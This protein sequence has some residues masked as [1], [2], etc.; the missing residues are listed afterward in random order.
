M[1]G[2]TTASNCNHMQVVNKNTFQYGATGLNKDMVTQEKSQPPNPI[3]GAK[4][5]AQLVG[6][7]VVRR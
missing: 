7:V 4:G 3:I 2:G 1:S 5:T 6:A